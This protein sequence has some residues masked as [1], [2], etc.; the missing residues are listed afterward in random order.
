M[1]QKEMRGVEA[2]G[3]LFLNGE[4]AS[5]A[6]KEHKQVKYLE[7]N[8]DFNNPEQV[9]NVYQKL[10]A[11]R[12]FR[13]PVGT[14]FLRRLQDYLVKKVD[15][16]KERIPAIPVDEPCERSVKKPREELASIRMATQKRK[17]K[18]ENS[19]K[20]SVILNFVLITAVLLMFWMTMQSDTPNMLNYRVALEN[21]YSSWEQELAQR[22]QAVREKELELKMAQ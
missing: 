10:I 6:E 2:E 5:L 3:F 9:L 16:G 4:D 7:K 12:T 21:R 1:E 11:E 8:M 13:T 22:E 18:Q 20:I 15:G 17:E 14:C 19:Y